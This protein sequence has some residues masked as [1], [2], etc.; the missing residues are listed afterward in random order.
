MSQ[1]AS[2]SPSKSVGFEGSND[3][4]NQL[5]TDRNN[6][7]V[8]DGLSTCFPADATVMLRGGVL[9]RMDQLTTGNDVLVRG[10]KFSKVLLFTHSSRW[11]RALFIELVTESQQVLSLTRGHYV[12]INGVLQRA[13]NARIGDNV[14]V[15]RKDGVGF[16]TT[17]ERVIKLGTKVRTGLYNPQT[18]AG[19]IVVNGILASC[20][21]DA[22]HPIAA[23][24]LLSPLRY[25]AYFRLHVAHRFVSKCV[26]NV[27]RWMTS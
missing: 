15:V 27:A 8:V 3:G 12:Y 5:G 14:L 11:T 21:T 22:V 9:T 7:D 10:G 1:T 23:H 13:E 19:D 2:S 25:F 16:N 4:N 24:S 26:E 6:T 18:V 17:Q 20:Y